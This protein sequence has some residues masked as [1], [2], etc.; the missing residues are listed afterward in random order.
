VDPRAARLI[1]AS[2]NALAA[3]YAQ[4]C[5]YIA[6]S[7]PLLSFSRYHPHSPPSASRSSALSCL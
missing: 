2:K 4:L 7:C 1:R 5:V 3:V 6:V